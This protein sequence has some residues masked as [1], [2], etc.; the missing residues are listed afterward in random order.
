VAYSARPRL[1]AP[2]A[3]HH[4]DTE[5]QGKQMRKPL[6]AF[7]LILTFRNDLLYASVSVVNVILNV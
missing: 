3:F 2:D 4:R 1:L 6:M 5:A 7:D